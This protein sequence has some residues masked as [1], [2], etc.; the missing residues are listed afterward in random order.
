MSGFEAIR[1]DAT[2]NQ[3]GHHREIE[4]LQWKYKNTYLPRPGLSYFDVVKIL[5]K[6][7]SSELVQS[8]DLHTV[9]ISIPTTPGEIFV[10]V[11]EILAV[12]LEVG[13]R[14]R[15]VRGLCADRTGT[16]IDKH[17]VMRSRVDRGWKFEY[18]VEYD[19]P[20][21]FGLMSRPDRDWNTAV[22]LMPENS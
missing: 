13:K 14:V 4:G 19:G 9:F 6:I 12:E 10:D 17:Q 3:K 1:R 16:I 22:E 5:Q 7:N 2:P 11:G 20:S 21:T 15:C 18:L 8:T